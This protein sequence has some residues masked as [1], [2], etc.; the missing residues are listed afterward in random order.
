MDQ[1]QCHVT[2]IVSVGGAVWIG[3]WGKGISVYDVMSKTKIGTWGEEEGASE[4]HYSNI[5]TS[6][7]T[8]NCDC[9]ILLSLISYLFISL[10]VYN[11]LYVKESSLMVALTSTSVAV[12]ETGFPAELKVARLEVKYSYAFA[13]TLTTGV[14]ITPHGKLEETEVWCCPLN[15]GSFKIL[16]HFDSRMFS[17]SEVMI[18]ASDVISTPKINNVSETRGRAGSLH[19]SCKYLSIN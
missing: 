14:V 13:P 6:I 1:L 9:F 2:C 10:A 12:L 4:L 16:T 17:F 19:L 3:T 11:L 15:G 18:P 5:I 8:N 7:M